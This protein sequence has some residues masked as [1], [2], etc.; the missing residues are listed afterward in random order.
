MSLTDIVK[1]DH[2]RERFVYSP[3]L[4]DHDV[5]IWNTRPSVFSSDSAFMSRP[6]SAAPLKPRPPPQPLYGLSKAADERIRL[7]EERM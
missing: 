2:K 4:P 7:F 3:P 5:F 1:F 6:S